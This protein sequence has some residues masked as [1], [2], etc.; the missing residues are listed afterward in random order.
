[1][2]MFNSDDSLGKRIAESTKLKIPYLLIIGEKEASDGTVTI[3]KRGE[4]EQKTVK[5]E[6]FVEMVKK[7]IEEKK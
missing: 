7:E 4:K 6:E 3:R 1:M 5:V 2:E